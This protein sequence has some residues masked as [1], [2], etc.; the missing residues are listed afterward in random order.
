MSTAKDS[1][2]SDRGQEIMRPNHKRG[3]VNRVEPQSTVAITSSPM[4]LSCFQNMECFQFCEKVKLLQ[5]HLELTRLFFLNLHNKQV[6]LAGVDF[7]LSADTISDATGIPAVGEKWF[8][9]AK[10]DKDYY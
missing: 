10:L 8:K 7:E 9:K 6:N 2:S 1:S 4:I 5:H 3:K